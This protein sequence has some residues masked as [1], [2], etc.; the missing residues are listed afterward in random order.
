MT[1]RKEGMESMRIW[2]TGEIVRRRMRARSESQMFE[3]LGGA[4][5]RSECQSETQ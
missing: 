1:R 2:R 3:M 4:R 5:A